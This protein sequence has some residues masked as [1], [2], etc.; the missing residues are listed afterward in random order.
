M[1]SLKAA[2]VAASAAGAVTVGGVTWAATGGQPQTDLR[3]GDSQAPAAVRQVKDVPAPTPTAPATRKLPT[4][5]TSAVC[6]PSVPKAPV[7]KGQEGKLCAPDTPRLPKKVLPSVRVPKL[8]ALPASVCDLAPAVQVGGTVE[9]TVIV[10]QGLKYVA[11]QRAVK[12]VDKRKVCTVTQRW[13][14]TAGRWLTVTRIQTPKGISEERLREVLKVDVRRTAT[15]LPGTVGRV[16]GGSGVFAYV[17]GGHSLLV[18]ADPAT[19]GKLTGV[20]TA[21]RTAA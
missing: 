17:P 2:L 12:V 20:V 11:V 19:A 9:R 8:P 13:T 6:V 5:P 16:T 15:T 1:I 18:N 10:R 4:P 14:G 21:L 3:S 7:V